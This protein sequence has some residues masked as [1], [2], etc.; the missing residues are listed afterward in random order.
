MT[1]F[2]IP[3]GRFRYLRAAMGLASSSD[4]F[5]ERT[6]AALQGLDGFVKLV[7]DILVF[8]D[9]LE[10]LLEKTR[11]ILSRCRENGITISQRKMQV[12][13][14]IPFAGYVLGKDG[15]KPDPKRIEAIMALQPPTD[16]SKLRSFL[17]AVNQ[18]SVFCPDLA[19]LTNLNRQL[20][21]KDTHFSWT[22][23]HQAAFESTKTALASSMR[24]NYFDPAR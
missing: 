11:A 6:D 13:T 18:L 1:T 16:V 20:L 17:G 21:K 19:H 23:E 22:P 5:C 9:N 15:I 12:G 3:Q 7:D 10:S 4:A 2:L 14:E 8:S 24:L